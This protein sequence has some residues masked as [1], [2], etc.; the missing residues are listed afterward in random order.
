MPRYRPNIQNS[1]ACSGMLSTIVFHIDGRNSGGTSRLNR[2]QNASPQASP[3]ATTSWRN[4]SRARWLNLAGFKSAFS[5]AAPRRVHSYREA[6][7]QR[8]EGEQDD[9]LQV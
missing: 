4:A 5:C 3:D 6:H 1:T 8:R 9:Y 7:V 2:S